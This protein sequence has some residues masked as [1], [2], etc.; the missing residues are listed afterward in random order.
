VEPRGR[1]ELVDVRSE[2]R[3]DVLEGNTVVPLRGLDEGLLMTLRPSFEPR[4]EGM[5]VP[6]L[7]NSKGCDN[8]E[9]WEVWLG[10]IPGE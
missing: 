1:F 5:F 10:V 3:S 6:G 4:V 8:R 9:L 2:P 7:V